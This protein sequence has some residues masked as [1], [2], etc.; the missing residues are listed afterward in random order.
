MLVVDSQVHIAGSGASRWTPRPDG[1]LG[2]VERAS[3]RRSEHALPDRDELLAQMD[4]AAVDAAVL[5]PL[6]AAG[7]NPEGDEPCAAAARYLPQRFVA[8]G[9]VDPTRPEQ[10]ARVAAWVQRPEILGVRVAIRADQYGSAAPRVY[11]QAGWLWSALEARQLPLMINAFG[12]LHLLGQMAAAHPDLPIVVDHLGFAGVDLGEPYPD[13]LRQLGT[14]CDLAAYPNVAVKAS[15]LPL[16]VRESYPFAHLREVV[17]RVVDAFGPSRVFWGSNLSRLPCSYRDAV[18][19]FRDQI[20]FLDGGE[21]AELL[22]Q[23]LVRW[24]GWKV[25]GRDSS[26]L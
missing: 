20:D 9:R 25:N 13:P 2:A 22:G 10:V 7:T 19:F 3:R 23:A 5:V 26:D 12:T 11:E 24:L 21:Q 4:L 8:M 18:A 15:G 17:R 6:A 14:L 1:G 16:L